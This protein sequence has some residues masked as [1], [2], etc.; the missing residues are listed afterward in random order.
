MAVLLQQPLPGFN[1]RWRDGRA[2]YRPPGEVIDT[3]KYEVAEIMTDEEARRYVVAMHY[4]KAYVAARL[5]FGLYRGGRL[6]GVAVFSHPCSNRVLTNTFPGTHPLE[7]I[8]LGRFVLDD[9]VEGN[10]ETW[11]LARC[12]EVL[13]QKGIVGVVSFSDPVPR[14]TITGEVRHVGHVGCIYQSASAR[15]LGRSTPRTLKL[16]PDA[17][18]LSDRSIQKIRKGE[19]GVRH[20]AQ[21]KNE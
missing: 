10:G 14:T 12:F 9:S 15:F 18:V 17:R 7:T 1:Q 2:S 21:R 6:T 16:L 4:S 3:S 8:E 13:R 19:R 11:M 5:R 20:E